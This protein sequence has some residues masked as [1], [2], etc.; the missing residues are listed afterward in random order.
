[1]TRR[2]ATPGA[3]QRQQRP[4][5]SVLPAG[6]FERA[7]GNELSAAELQLVQDFRRMNG[8]SRVVLARFVSK[9]AAR[10]REVRMAGNGASLRLVRGGAV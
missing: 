7:G 6:H 3:A 9:Q 8:E 1:M 10:D 2:D 5:M 4:A